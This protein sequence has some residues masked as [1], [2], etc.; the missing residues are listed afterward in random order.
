MKRKYNIENKNAW[1][2]LKWA[3][4][5]YSIACDVQ[6]YVHKQPPYNDNTLQSI[7]K[8]RRM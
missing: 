4:M 1:N 6:I 8:E 7:Q 2:A 3:K 5:V